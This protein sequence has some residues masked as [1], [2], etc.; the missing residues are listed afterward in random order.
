MADNAGAITNGFEFEF[1]GIRGNCWFHVTKAIR[2]RLN[3]LR[4]VTKS[5]LLNSDINI[6]HLSQTPIVFKSG[7]QSCQILK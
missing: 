4:D 5:K 7:K 3:K 1:E 6:L 2:P